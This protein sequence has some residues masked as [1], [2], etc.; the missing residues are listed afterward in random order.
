MDIQV[1]KHGLPVCPE[2]GEILDFYET[3]GHEKPSGLWD[4][5]PEYVID[6]WVYH[7]PECGNFYKSDIEL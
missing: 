2:C 7:C 1:N 5:P 6:A 3:E 4:V